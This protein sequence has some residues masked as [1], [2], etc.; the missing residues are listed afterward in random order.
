[1]ITAKED[2]WHSEIIRIQNSQKQ[3]NPD[4]TVVTPL[5]SQKKKT[6]NLEYYSQKNTLQRGRQNIFH[7]YKGWV[8]QS[9]AHLLYKKC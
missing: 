4:N 1:M 7:I 2:K 6:I 3:R 5:K 9:P 8:S